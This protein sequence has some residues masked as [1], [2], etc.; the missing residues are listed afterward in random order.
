MTNTLQSCY[1]G[2]DHQLP[3]LMRICSF[4]LNIWDVGGQKSLRSYWRNYFEQTDSMIWVIDSADV[5]RMLDCRDE[6]H[7]LLKEE[8]LAG[9]TLLIFANKQDIGGALSDQQIEQVDALS[10]LALLN[11]Y[12]NTLSYV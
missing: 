7:N 9:A 12:G 10:S 11:A 4:R 3:P 1:S 8:K 6:L 5:H 2:R